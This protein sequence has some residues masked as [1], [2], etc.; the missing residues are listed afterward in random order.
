MPL[1]KDL[2]IGPNKLHVP[3]VNNTNYIECDSMMHYVVCVEGVTFLN[4][5]IG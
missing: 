1:F 5:I 3:I 2:V 4:V